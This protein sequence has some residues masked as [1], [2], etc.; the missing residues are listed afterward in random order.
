MRIIAVIGPALLVP[1]FASCLEQPP[2]VRH[3][4]YYHY[5]P[6]AVAVATPP[7]AEGPGVSAPPSPPPVVT[8]AVVAPPATATTPAETPPPSQVPSKA[9]AS[10]D[11]GSAERQATEHEPGA[12]DT[13]VRVVALASQQI[14]RLSRILKS[15]EDPAQRHDVESILG[16]L[17]RQREKVLQDLSELELDPAA[18]DRLRQLLSG[19]LLDLQRSVTA[20]YSTAPPPSQGL[21]SPSP[22]PPSEAW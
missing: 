7:V 11:E 16:E 18:G 12:R 5:P 9:A 10:S 13:A 3:A 14:E 19:D 22:L 4:Y 1:A 2:R 6:P 15:A 21:P 20:S 8:A 17:E